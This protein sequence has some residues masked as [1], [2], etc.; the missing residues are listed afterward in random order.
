MQAKGG[1]VTHVYLDS[2]AIVKRYVKEIGS[3]SVDILYHELERESDSLIIF[4]AW[5]LGEVY[6]AID[7]KH[8]RGDISKEAMIEA[9][10]LLSQETKKF[11]AMKRVRIIPLGA[12]ILAKSRDLIVKYHIYQADA[13]QLETAKET[14]AEIFISS[15]RRLV[16]CAKSELL[17]A[18][19]PEKDYDSVHEKISGIEPEENAS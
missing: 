16:D 4:S 5:N 3:D 7:T 8:Q 15:D 1:V 12:R 19:N 11:V 10:S 18:L 17:Q 6:G 2:S 14:Q 13:L 9:L